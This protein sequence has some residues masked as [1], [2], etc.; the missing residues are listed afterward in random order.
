MELGL[1]YFDDEEEVM[2]AIPVC[3]GILKLFDMSGI[4]L[5]VPGPT[6][7]PVDCERTMLG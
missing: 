7:V 4:F 5:R 3:D 6:T 2:A 1:T